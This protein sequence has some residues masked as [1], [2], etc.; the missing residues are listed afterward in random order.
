MLVQGS[1]NHYAVF[2]EI[3]RELQHYWILVRA[4]N[5]WSLEYIGRTGQYQYAPKRIDCKAKTA[6]GDV[7][8]KPW[9]LKGLVASPYLHP[10]AFTDLNDAKEQWANTRIISTGGKNS[11]PYYSVDLNEKSQHYGC[12]IL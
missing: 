11:G 9:K 4:T 3:A 10:L 7:P 1:V 2:Q 5:V 12:L 8:G 6:K